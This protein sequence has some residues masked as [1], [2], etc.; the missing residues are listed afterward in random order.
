MKEKLISVRV[1][2][3]KYNKVINYVQNNKYKTYPA[4]SFAD[5]V[6]DAIDKFIQDEK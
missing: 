2:S 6:E 4:L 1:D 5:I 3:W